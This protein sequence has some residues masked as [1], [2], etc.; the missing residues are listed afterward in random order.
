MAMGAADVIPGVSGGTIAFITGIYEKLIGSLNSVDLE[1]VKLLFTGKWKALEEKINGYFLIALVSGILLAVLSLAKLIKFL[2][3]NHEIAL[4][5][6]FFGL[7]VASTF[8]IGKTIKWEI[9]DFIGLIAGAAI[10]F[11]LTTVSPIDMPD[12]PLYLFFAGVISIIAMIL[13]GISGSFILVILGKY[14][15]IISIVSDISEG[16]KGIIS[17]VIKGDFNGI[18]PYWASMDVLTLLI[19]WLGTLTGILGFSRVLNWLFSKFRNLTIAL[20][21]GFMIGSL[22]KVWPWKHT[23][24]IY[25]DRHGNV[26]PLVQESV[27][28]GTFNELTGNESF[29]STALGLAILGFAIV[30]ILEYVSNKKKLA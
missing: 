5:S 16:L 9:K 13:P 19:F 25:T 4:W 17:S 6:F 7:I 15:Y 21:T 26:R 22:N 1:A 2:L 14:K 3:S 20:L 27:L 18:P 28:P 11:Y 12:T 10:A 23:I 8:V 24:S 29:L 30:F